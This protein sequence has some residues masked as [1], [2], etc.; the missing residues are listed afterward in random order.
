MQVVLMQV[1]MPENYFLVREAQLKAGRAD[2][3]D[4]G[5]SGRPGP[6]GQRVL[7]NQDC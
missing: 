2:L 3:I 1:F 6:P 4:G 7:P 5:K